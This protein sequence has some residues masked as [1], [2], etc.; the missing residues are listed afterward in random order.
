MKVGV[1]T[2]IFKLFGGLP[3]SLIMKILFFLVCVSISVAWWPFTESSEEEESEIKM[4]DQSKD[5]MIPFETISA[6]QKFLQEAKELLDLSPLD[7]CQYKVSQ[8]NELL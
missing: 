2:L 1:A 4:D 5:N 3:S 8:G 6:E 7:K